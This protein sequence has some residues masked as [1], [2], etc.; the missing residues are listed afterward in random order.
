MRGPRR[1][2]GTTMPDAPPTEEHSGRPT[3][4]RGCVGK[5]PPNEPFKGRSRRST[6][7]RHSHRDRYRV[8][9]RLALIT[10]ACASEDP[11]LALG[12]GLDTKLGGSST[13]GLAFHR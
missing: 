4:A 7:P 1:R 9:C 8:S 2:K 11:Q 10:T 13:G 6:D 3:S 5:Q 12:G